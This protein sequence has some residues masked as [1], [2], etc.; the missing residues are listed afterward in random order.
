MKHPKINDIPDILLVKLYILA[1]EQ[2]S[3]GFYSLEEL[4]DEVVKRGRTFDE[5][6]T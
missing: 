3:V 1:K 6:I 5:E 2:N 4:E